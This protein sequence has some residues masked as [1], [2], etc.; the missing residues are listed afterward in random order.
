VLG[1]KKMILREI[2]FLKLKNG[3]RNYV[4]SYYQLGKLYEWLNEVEK[5][6]G[7]YKTGI[8]IAQKIENK[9]TL[10]ELQEAYNMLIEIDE[11][12]F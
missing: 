7:I 6:M 12:G 4:A 2:T 11:D 5:A 8:E 10:S 3:D 9:N 1:L